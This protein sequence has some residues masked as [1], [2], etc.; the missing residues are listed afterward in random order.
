MKLK[1]YL[2]G[3][4]IGMVVTALLMG[5]SEDKQVSAKGT[6]S[7]E[8]EQTT[9]QYNQQ[10]ETEPV[11]VLNTEEEEIV[12]S[13]IQIQEE[14]TNE[15]ETEQN[16]EMEAEPVTESEIENITDDVQ[17]ET[18]DHT[19][20][21]SEEE[22]STEELPKEVKELLEMTKNASSYTLEIVRGDDSGTVSRKLQNAGL[23]EN[24]SE[25]DAFLMQ[26]GY[27]KKISI[28]TVVIPKDASWVEIAEKL[29][30]K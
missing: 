24:A 2:R 26:H 3:L 20:Q 29:A 27:D 30:G 7:V 22:E 25:F 1:Y 18:E 15:E 8:T 4:G 28:G 17:V 9:E 5:A 6:A 19:E 10:V 23:I 21:E 16:M 14:S 13:Q 12:S 11:V